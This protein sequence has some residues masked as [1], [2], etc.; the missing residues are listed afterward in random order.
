M[1]TDMHAQAMPDADRASLARPDEVA[2]RIADL[3]ETDGI[4]SGT[5]IEVAALARVA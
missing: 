3:V 1:D 4:R 5:R 2:E